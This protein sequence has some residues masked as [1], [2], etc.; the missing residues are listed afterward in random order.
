MSQANKH[1]CKNVSKKVI[2][3]V[4]QKRV[5]VTFFN[6]AIS[7]FNFWRSAFDYSPT[8]YFQLYHEELVC[9]T[10][11]PQEIGNQGSEEAE[12]AE[13][14]KTD[15]NVAQLSVFFHIFDE[16]FHDTIMVPKHVLYN[17]IHLKSTETFDSQNLNQ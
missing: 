4:V 16:F 2:C 11:A 14:Y 6:I 12:K 15:T 8:Y 9:S 1:F 17:S 13:E 7:L 5:G 3:E 10:F